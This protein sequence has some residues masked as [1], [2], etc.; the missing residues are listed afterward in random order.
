MIPIGVCVEGLVKTTLEKFS[1]KY[2][3]KTED[4]NIRWI[5]IPAPGQFRG[6]G[7]WFDYDERTSSWTQEQKDEHWNHMKMLLPTKIQEEKPS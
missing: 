3:M 5:K 6:E 2:E 7:E 1:W 4:K